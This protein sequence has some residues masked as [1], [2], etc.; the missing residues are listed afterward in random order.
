MI[1][2]IR[3]CID[4]SRL[5]R[6]LDLVDWLVREEWLGMVVVVRLEGHLEVGSLDSLSRTPWCFT[7][8][9]LG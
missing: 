2:I 4:V 7:C 5:E 9:K 8:Y 3:S 1:G 6:M